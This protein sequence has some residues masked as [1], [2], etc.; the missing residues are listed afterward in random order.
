MMHS[1]LLCGPAWLSTFKR[2]A[3]T[4]NTKWLRALERT[5]YGI[6]QRHPCSPCTPCKW[7]RFGVIS[8]NVFSGRQTE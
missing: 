3:W 8:G 7:V 5:G 6:R 4:R 1:T 2:L